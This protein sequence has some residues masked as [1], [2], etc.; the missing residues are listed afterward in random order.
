M[1]PLDKDGIETVSYIHKYCQARKG[2]A[3]PKVAQPGSGRVGAGTQASRCQVLFIQ[4]ATLQ[5][6]LGFQGR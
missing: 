6:K 3:S 2:T 4:H 1:F 5:G